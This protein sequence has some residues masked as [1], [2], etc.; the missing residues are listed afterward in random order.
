MLLAGNDIQ[1]LLT[2]RFYRSSLAGPEF[3]LGS[4][5]VQGH[6][7]AVQDLGTLLFRIQKE[8]GLCGVVAGIEVQLAGL[9]LFLRHR[10]LAD[11]GTHSDAAGVQDHVAGSD[12]GKVALLNELSHRG[13]IQ[14][15][16]QTLRRRFIHQIC[17]QQL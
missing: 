3:D 15:D 8:L 10:A 2:H 1:E 7:E 6:S 17:S 16:P 12:L 11:M 4:A 9:H 13:E 14:V 5:L